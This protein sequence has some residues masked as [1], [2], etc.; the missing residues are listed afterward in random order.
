MDAAAEIG[1]MRQTNFPPFLLLPVLVLLSACGGGGESADEPAIQAFEVPADASASAMAASVE[2]PTMV[3]A[4]AALAQPAAVSDSTRIAAAKATAESAS[5][6][7]APIRPFYWEIGN[8]DSKS[9]AGSVNS[10]TSTVKVTSTLPLTIA[11]ASKWI[12]G[13]Y[14]VQQRNGVLSDSDISLLSMRGG[15]T[16]FGGCTPTQTVDSCLA[17][18]T[19]GVLEPANVGKFDYGGGHMQKHASLMGLGALNKKGL[20][21]AIQASLGSDVKIA[22]SQPQLAGGILA[23]SDA[24]AQFLRKILG[25]QLRMGAMLG[26]TPACTNK[27]TCPS[28][29]AVYAP[30]PPNES[31][32]YS[33]GH[34]VEDDPK[35][36][37]GAFSSPGAFG[38]YPWID[39]GRT[40]YGIVARS[41]PGGAFA[42]VKCGRLIRKAWL[43][44][45]AL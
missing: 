20:V 28:G 39:A 8:R 25:G 43:S 40:T 26:T 29:Q 35:V 44:G 31:W 9:V 21:T 23:S 17:Y 11:S 33:I 42:S 22:Y 18:Q 36:G 24:Y 14:V 27:A 13:S 16:L 38:F 19:N 10:T 30:I 12:Y 32:H 1:G 15:Y 4:Q 41:V 5:N 45:S 34:W 7:C 37:D 2:V 3:T 6:E